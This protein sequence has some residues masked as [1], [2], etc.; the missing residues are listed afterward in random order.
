MKD[1][2]EHPEPEL[3]LYIPDCTLGA[4]PSAGEGTFVVAGKDAN[5]NQVNRE[6]LHRVP[7]YLLANTQTETHAKARIRL[8]G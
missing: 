1:F 2:K 8:Q 5:K 3:S 4:P 7:D 6:A